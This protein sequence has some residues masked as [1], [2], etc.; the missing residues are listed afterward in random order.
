MPTTPPLQPSSGPRAAVALTVA[1]HELA[2]RKTRRRRL[3]L[4]AVLSMVL[5]PA[6]GLAVWAA[7]MAQLW[8]CASQRP[9][10][11]AEVVREAR[12]TNAAIE[13][14]ALRDHGLQWADNVETRAHWES[15]RDDRP[16]PLDPPPGPFEIEIEEGDRF[17]R[18]ANGTH[19]RIVFQ[20]DRWDDRRLR[21]CGCDTRVSSGV[22]PAGRVR[23]LAHVGSSYGGDLMV[24]IPVRVLTDVFLADTWCPDLPP[25]P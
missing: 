25:A 2:R 23:H 11:Y 9:A 14:Q 17:V 8:G 13:E 18:N 20:P 19:F 24:R 10:H 12:A 16:D 6:V 15:F 7:Y 22:P 21:K 4:S 5:V 3:L 1:Q